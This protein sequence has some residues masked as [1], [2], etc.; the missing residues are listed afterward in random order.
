MPAPNLRD[1][2]AYEEL[3][4][5]WVSTDGVVALLRREH[6]HSSW[7]T[8]SMFSA[9]PAAGGAGET[10]AVSLACGKA[11]YSL[12]KTQDGLVGA[13]MLLS[14]AMGPPMSA[15]GGSVATVFHD[16]ISAAAH[17]RAS[18]YSIHRL[19][20]NYRG[21]APLNQTLRLT[22]TIPF[23]EP[24]SAIV[25]RL[26]ALATLESAEGEEGVW[27]LIDEAEAEL[28]EFPEHWGEPPQRE[29]L[30][31]ATANS[32]SSRQGSE[33]FTRWI[34]AKR[35]EDA[36]RATCFSCA[37]TA[38]G[39]AATH[40]DMN[41]VR[42]NWLDEGGWMARLKS[43]LTSG[44]LLSGHGSDVRTMETGLLYGEYEAFPSG[45][46]LTE[47]TSISIRNLLSV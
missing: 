39:M 42:A 26:G 1:R 14:S 2:A 34:E 25:G 28:R 12:H 40:D 6:G 11:L 23:D 43:K 41:A 4:R 16:C 8:T 3:H 27:G 22:V 46:I 37:S 15:H 9:P 20:V 33:S 18:D 35:A 21:T 38:C 13:V 31:Q 47:C 17:V 44:E 19:R 36:E 32:L 45:K 10:T 24:D 29:A 7:D 30:P 5:R